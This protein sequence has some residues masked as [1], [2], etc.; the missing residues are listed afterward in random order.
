MLRS[1]PPAL[2]LLLAAALPATSEDPAANVAAR[3]RDWAAALVSKDMA[4]L[5]A[6]LHPD[7]RLVPLYGAEPMSR[8]EYLIHQEEAPEWRFTSM[9]PV[10]IR[11]EHRDGVVV[12]TVLMQVGWP[13]GV[14]MP[15]GFR[16]TDIWVP[17]DGGW[18]VLVRYS[19][20]RDAASAPL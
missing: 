3:E 1:L 9:T 8:P 20:L 10:A 18:R 6:L 2:L 4:T 14:S 15:P 11:A 17:M 12:A 5:D 13:D 7:F 19:E 16:F